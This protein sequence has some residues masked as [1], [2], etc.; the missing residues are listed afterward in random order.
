VARPEGELERGDA[1]RVVGPA[2][3]LRV[4]R[5]RCARVGRK[6]VNELVEN[7]T[8]VHEMD[9][10]EVRADEAVLTDL[11]KLASMQD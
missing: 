10:N 3:A 9:E 2:E 7:Y 5:R 8:L 6:D 11:C 1:S 4:P